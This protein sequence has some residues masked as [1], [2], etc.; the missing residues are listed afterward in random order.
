MTTVATNKDF[1]VE[2]NGKE[3]FFVVDGNGDCWKRYKTQGAAVR[4]MDKVAA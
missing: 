4:Y 1:R 2:F 3:A